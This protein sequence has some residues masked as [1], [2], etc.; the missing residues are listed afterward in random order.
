M[1]LQKNCQFWGDGA[2]RWL[3]RGFTVD[4]IFEVSLKRW[5]GVCQEEDSEARGAGKRFMS[6]GKG[7]INL[8]SCK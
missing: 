4:A 6:V 7:R 1:Q 8:G 3:A 5:L 2:R